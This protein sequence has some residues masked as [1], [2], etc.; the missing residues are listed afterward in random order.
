MDVLRAAECYLDVCRLIFHEGLI[1]LSL[2]DL[3]FPF[4]WIKF[5]AN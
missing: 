5:S 3:L 2:R 4:C 1:R